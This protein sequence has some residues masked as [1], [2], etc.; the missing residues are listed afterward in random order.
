MY[1]LITGTNDTI[2][3]PFKTADAAAAHARNQYPMAKWRIAPLLKV[4]G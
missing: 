4:R 2:I 3:G 1:V